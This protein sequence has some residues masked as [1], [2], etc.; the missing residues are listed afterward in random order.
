MTQVLI[1]VR[2]MFLAQMARGGA[3]YHYYYKGFGNA[4]H[5]DFA[6]TEM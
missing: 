6:L 5:V 3:E 2:D 1:G 4:I